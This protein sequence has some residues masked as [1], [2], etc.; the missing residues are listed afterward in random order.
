MA[1]ETQATEEVAKEAE[2]VVQLKS[3]FPTPITCLD[4]TWGSVAIFGDH[5]ISQQMLEMVRDIFSAWDEWILTK[6]KAPRHHGVH[7]IVFRDDGHPKNADGE[8]VFA[9]CL[10]TVGGIAVNLE[11]VFD[12]AFNDAIETPST[13]IHCN[14]FSHVMLAIMHEMD[15]L[16]RLYDNTPNE[17]AIAGDIAKELEKKAEEFSMDFSMFLA[18][19]YDIATGALN[20]EPFFSVKVLSTLAEY[21]Q[22]AD[23]MSKEDMAFFK[24]Q[25]KMALE[26]IL[27]WPEVKKDEQPVILKNYREY[28]H[29]VDGSEKD[30]P[31]W[32]KVYEKP[33]AEPVVAT[34]A[35]TVIQAPPPA[36]EAPAAEPVVEQNAYTGESTVVVD[37]DGDMHA[38][39]MS[40]MGQEPP[41][42]QETDQNAS[43]V[44][45]D[46]PPAQA[47]TVITPP[48]VQ[49]PMPNSSVRL[50][51]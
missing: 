5:L 17:G 2:V 46:T 39:A 20:E 27:F 13:S 6:G 47:Q 29:W 15:H 33:A 28:L 21:T 22:G 50:T 30:D 36:V 4:G 40:M 11:K 3:E 44:V 16:T 23:S 10:P 41:W 8:L 37:D 51:D 9:H 38:A 34:P 43:I 25:Q 7:S 32:A 35:E 18:Q 42:E 45:D 31:K 19:N 1:E 24:K 14:I 26:N 12:K 49:E 48:P